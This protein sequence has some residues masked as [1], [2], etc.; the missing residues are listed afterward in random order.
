MATKP[1]A[2]HN[3]QC[4]TPRC[5]ALSICFYSRVAEVAPLKPKDRLLIFSARAGFREKLYTYDQ[6]AEALLQQPTLVSSRLPPI[7]ALDSGG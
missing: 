5:Y 6:F 7:L 3:C 2:A 4:Y 1:G